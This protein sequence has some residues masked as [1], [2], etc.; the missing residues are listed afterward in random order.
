M[1][2]GMNINDVLNIDTLRIGNELEV[3]ETF[4]CIP[5]PLTTLKKG[6]NEYLAV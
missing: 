2:I 4:V 1:V 3:D 6:I 5:L